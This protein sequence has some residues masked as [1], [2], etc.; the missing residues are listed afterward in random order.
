MLQP[1]GH[2]LL[3]WLRL[4]HTS[5]SL[6]SGFS[7]EFGILKSCFS[8]S[9]G[10]SESVRIPS[11]SFTRLSRTIFRLRADQTYGRGEALPLRQEGAF[12]DVSMLR[13]PRKLSSIK[14]GQTY[15]CISLDLDTIAAIAD[16]MI[17]H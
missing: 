5:F 3:S 12:L 2:V 11:R 14:Y 4:R 13:I 7:R 1:P 8:E 6:S 10:V 17:N 15:L 9:E 16:Q